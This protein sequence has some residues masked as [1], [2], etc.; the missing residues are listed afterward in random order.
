MDLNIKTNENNG[1]LKRQEIVAETSEKITPSK[2]LVQEKLAAVLNIPKEQI[3]VSKIETGFGSNHA[4]IYA[5][6]YKSEEQMKEVEPKY[7]VSRNFKE[8]PV[9]E[10]KEEAK[11]EVEKKAEEPK[12][13]AVP[14]EEAPTKEEAPAAAEEK[15]KEKPV[16][17]AKEEVAEEKPAEEA[18]EKPKEEKK[19]EGE[20]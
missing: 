20:Q 16:E 2:E 17:E 6:A 14:T 9:E 1:V 7:M 10:P 13:E 12:E 4:T 11:P 3:V 18:K 19:K 8:A 15:A 5:R